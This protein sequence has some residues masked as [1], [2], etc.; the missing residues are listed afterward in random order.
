LKKKATIKDFLAS[1]K[2]LTSP[3]DSVE[4]RTRIS[5]LAFYICIHFWNFMKIQTVIDVDRCYDFEE[6]FI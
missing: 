2:P 4:S 3:K 5:S 6:I 1:M